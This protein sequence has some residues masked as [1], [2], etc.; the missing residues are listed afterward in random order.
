MRTVTDLNGVTWKAE[1]DDILGGVPV[2]QVAIVFTSP[3]GRRRW[4]PVVRGGLPRMQP[5]ELLQ[6][7]Q[8]AAGV[9]ST[10]PPPGTP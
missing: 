4:A 5:P 6:L 1:E 7:L 2:H 8:K 9:A 10:L 3:D